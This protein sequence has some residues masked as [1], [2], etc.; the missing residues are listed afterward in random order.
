MGARK[1]PGRRQR[2]NTADVGVVVPLPSRPIEVPT[3]DPNWLKMTSEWWA[4]FWR[5]DVAALVD[6]ASDL[7]ALRR[8]FWH[9]DELERSRRAFRRQRFV[10]GYKGQPRVNPIAKYIA[11]L[12]GAARHLEDRFGLTPKAR[13]QLGV[14]FASA[15]RSLAEISAEFA[16]AA[17]DEDP[18]R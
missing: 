1:P 14:S 11:E 15:H 7:A 2:R 6:Q 18:R 16:E 12:E 17:D 13:L 3:A 5:S 9:Y 4:E 8:L 10:A